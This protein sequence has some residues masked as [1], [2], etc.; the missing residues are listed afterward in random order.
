MS[1]SRGSASSTWRS[2]SNAS[3]IAF[4]PSHGRAECAERPSKTT[5][6]FRLP[7]QPSC[8]VLS[9]GS[10]Q[11]TS[12]ASSTRP[13]RSNTPGSG[14][15]AGPSSSRGKK[16][17]ARSY[18]SSVLGGPARELDHD[19]EPALHVARAEPDHRAVV[20]PAREVALRRDGVR[21]PGEEDQRA[22]RCA[23]RRGA[24]RRRRTPARAAGRPRHRRS[25]P[26]PASIPTGCRP[27][28]ASA[29][30]G[31]CSGRERA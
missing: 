4:T 2:P 6:A 25:T 9:V 10:R 8:S 23:S 30:P 16:S 18:A 1:T 22:G 5:R 28:R 7:R 11:T 21:V 24:T 31:P 12:S 26:L 14:F 27:A 3:R 17:S 29:A 19:G 15:S 20:D 13:A